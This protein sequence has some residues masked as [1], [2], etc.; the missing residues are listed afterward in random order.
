MTTPPAS[1]LSLQSLRDLPGLAHALLTDTDPEG[2]DRR[3]VAEIG[4][5]EGTAAAVLAWGR[6]AAAVATDRDLALDDVI[7]TTDTAHHLLRAVGTPSAGWIYVRVHRDGGNLALARRRLAALTTRTPAVTRTPA[8]AA[9]AELP[10]GPS[11]TSAPRVPSRTPSAASPLAV[12]SRSWPDRG[13]STISP[14]PIRPP[15]A[16]PASAPSGPASPAAPV[17]A[18]LPAASSP[19]A[20][21]RPPARAPARPPATPW[22]AGPARGTPRDSSRDTSSAPSP[23]R[24]VPDTAPDLP[25]PRRPPAA[26]ALPAIPATPDAGPGDGTAAPQGS[27]GV[28]GQR[29]RSDPET[30]RRVLAGLLRLGRTPR[31]AVAGGPEPTT[32][33]PGAT[34][35]RRNP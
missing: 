2:H 25:R 7:V 13:P 20:T 12:G 19:P 35:T 18:A 33:S 1:S 23:R 26:S 14:P 21:S 31:A 32:R 8:P 30:L 17:P 6:R 3:V 9:R 4:T 34:P 24:G 27:A 22:A 10:P 15:A 16:T 5:D 11:S 28:L 29:W